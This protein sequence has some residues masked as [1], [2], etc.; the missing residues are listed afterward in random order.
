M[1]PSFYEAKLVF[2]I[3][4]AIIH[5]GYY[6]FNVSVTQLKIVIFFKNVKYYDMNHAQLIIWS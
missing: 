3:F 4:L 1:D 2:C 6:D 5:F